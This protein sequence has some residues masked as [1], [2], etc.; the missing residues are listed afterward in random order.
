MSMMC[1][2]ALSPVCVCP[3]AI[4]HCFLLYLPLL[5]LKTGAFALPIIQNLYEHLRG[6]AD[7]SQTICMRNTAA[8]DAAGSANAAAA[9]AT[10]RMSAADRDPIC[11]VDESGFLTQAR[12]AQSWAGV[13]C[14]LGVRASRGARFM[15]EC[16]VTDEGLCRVGWSTSS[17]ARA[18]GTDARGFGY[19]GTGK[20]SSANKFEDYGAPFGLGDVI[21]CALDATEAGVAL[22]FSKNG[23]DLGVAF[24]VPHEVVASEGGGL[25]PAVVLKNAEMRFNFGAEPFK[26]PR[27]GF[28]PIASATQDQIVTPVAPAPANS[29]APAAASSSSNSAAA[30]PSPFALIIEPTREL[31]L[32]VSEQ[33]DKFTSHLTC[34]RLTHFCVVG[35]T[36]MSS[37]TRALR[38]GVHILIGTPQ[39]IIELVRTK[40]L[41]VSATRNLVL[42][43]ADQLVAPT[44]P[45]TRDGILH[46]CDQL[47]TTSKSLQI[48]VC[49]ATLHSPSIQE[50]ASKV[51]RNATWVDLKGRD[52]VPDSVD[53]VVVVADPNADRAW[54]D[55]KPSVT[56]DGV[57]ADIDLHGLSN[58]GAA[59][60]PAQVS[61]GIKRL[62]FRILLEIIDQFQMDQC[63]IF[64]R[65]Q[66]D[67]DHCES[68]L[69]SAGGGGTAFKGRR[70]T[71]KENRYSCA[72]LHGGR[73]PQERSRNLDAF[74]SGD[75]RFLI[76][77][78]VAARGIDVA[79]LPFVIN[80]CLPD[81]PETY[82]HRVGRVG[83]AD[84]VGLAISVVAAADAREQVWWH[85]CQRRDKGRGCTDTRATSEGG[86]TVWLDEHQMLKQVETRLGGISVPV[87]ARDNLAQGA[88]HVVQAASKGR[89]PGQKATNRHCHVYAGNCV[90]AVLSFRARPLTALCLLCFF[91][92]PPVDDVT[93]QSRE[94]VTVLRPTVA[95][96]SRLEVTAQYTFWEVQQ[97]NKWREMLR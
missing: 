66:L 17:A 44:D 29:A 35:G 85:T 47:P 91:S 1:P 13:R 57:H 78:D 33:L 83:R 51:T 63:M 58:R 24:V 25:F 80:M 30:S 92:L 94:H 12:H 49:S 89:K 4:H 14:A 8:G 79:G 48:I 45:A 16:T 70:E 68:F 22:S 37:V 26:H 32:Q 46:V 2:H 52:A 27:Q 53:H 41:D 6:D 81:A 39:R 97:S 77:T 59:L 34:P 60:S 73:A 50:L 40:K 5:C 65:T 93:A 55:N 54:L 7:I 84:A 87:I 62:K 82:I 72:V 38:G 42:D 69:L 15:F 56:T 64:M 90:G 74:K 20:R 18:L 76:A 9:A 11:A 88:Q 67:C 36:D 43:E 3:S 86:C 61:E 28:A 23:T 10:F 95:E 75:V 19:G 31:A 71:G 96:L 21:G